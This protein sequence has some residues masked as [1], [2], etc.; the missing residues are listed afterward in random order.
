M[1]TSRDSFTEQLITQPAPRGRC[2]FMV[3]LE[4]PGWKEGF[5]QV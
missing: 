3:S 1:E 4:I 5:E 2:D